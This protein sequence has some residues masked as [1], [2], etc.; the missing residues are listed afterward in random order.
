MKPNESLR[1]TGCQPVLQ[2]CLLLVLL[3]GC[4]GVETEE[5]EHHMPPHM[6]VNFPAA[7]ERLGE[8][9]EEIRARPLAA[10]TVGG[11]RDEHK[12]DDSG[13]GNHHH[14]DHGH[15][16]DQHHSHVTLDALQEMYDVV[17]WLPDL[18]ADSDL[19][20]EPWNRVDRV[21]RRYQ[22]L[23][24]AALAQSGDSRR[25]IYV[26]NETELE[27]LRRELIE[28]KQVFPGETNRVTRGD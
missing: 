18:A 28:I 7:V 13:N 25:Q 17:Q 6:P 4:H 19:E 23:L 27:K 9:H 11:A 1:R 14:H 16:H 22:A 24:A 26:D 12:P 2:T 8:L 21:S 15:D 3:A 20:E 10:R 5:A